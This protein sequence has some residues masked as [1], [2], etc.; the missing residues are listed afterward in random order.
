MNN[1]IKEFNIYVTYDGDNV[2]IYEYGSDG[3]KYE[4][5]NEKIKLPEK[6][7]KKAIL[8]SI[9]SYIDNYCEIEDRKE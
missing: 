2:T 9:N 8:N 1:K 5:N 7:I 3:V 4:I 6:L